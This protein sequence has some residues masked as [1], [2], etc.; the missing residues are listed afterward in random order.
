MAVP[1]N[2]F[3]L[4]TGRCGSMT[5]ARACTHFDNYTAAHEGRTH[6]VGAARFAFP[7]R[8]IEIDNRLSWLLGRLDRHWGDRAAYVHLTRD[9]EEVAQSFRN[10]AGQGIIKAYKDVI[11]ARSTAR[12]KKVPVLEFCRDYVDTVTENITAFLGDK[13]HV[14]HIRLETARTDF[15]RFSDWIGATGDLDSALAEFSVR[16]NATPSEKDS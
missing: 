16:H 11:I 6:H 2:I 15:P 14:M 8:H 12:A 1:T 4:C 13:T 3:V 9:P 5:L 10:R 7:S